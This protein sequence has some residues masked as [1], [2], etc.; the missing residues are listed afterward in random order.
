MDLISYR[1]PHGPGGVST[2]L[3]SAWSSQ[4]TQ[5]AYW[6]FLRDGA[7]Q[8]SAPRQNASFITQIAEPIVKGHYRFCNEFLWPILHD[9]PQ[10]AAYHEE[11]RRHYRKFNRL[12][13][14]YI[15]FEQRRYKKFFVND[16]QLA[17]LPRY[18][19]AANG[20]SVVFWHIPWPKKVA[21]A[22]A[23]PLMEVARALLHAEMLGFHI[24]EY[25][26]NFVS[27]VCQYMPQYNVQSDMQFVCKRN[28]DE[29]GST[30]SSQPWPQLSFKDSY[31]ARPYLYPVA[32]P[33]FA[34][35]RILSAPLG[36]DIEQWQSMAD[37]KLNPAHGA[38]EHVFSQLRGQRIILS[39]DRADYTKSVKERM[40]IV[41]RFFTTNSDWRGKAA[42][43]QICTRS[44]TGLAAFDRYWSE[45]QEIADRVNEKWRQDNWQPIIWQQESVSLEALAGLYRFADAMLVNPIRDGLNLTAKEFV[46]C[47][48]ENAGVLMLSPG[49]GAWRELGEF[50]LP[51]DPLKSDEV[52]TSIERSL[53]MTSYERAVR[54]RSLQKIVEANPLAKWWKAV[55]QPGQSAA[56]A[57]TIIHNTVHNAKKIADRALSA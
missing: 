45:C 8:Y 48:R 19:S 30:S 29:L 10:Y 23:E 1:G 28:G 16:Y 56:A 31:I 22:H 39:V 53:K 47:Q 9:L 2:G 43:L 34:G 50:A 52:I 4:H 6:W 55:T 57:G 44:R 32:K 40:E 25:A 49:T 5:G 33:I 41:D 3:D 38:L 26:Q 54:N 13:G 17:L 14:Q 27:F 11:D 18:L 15:G 37:K 21:P 51:A 12:F 24:S 36:V 20:R 46:V 7:L 42:F 35:T